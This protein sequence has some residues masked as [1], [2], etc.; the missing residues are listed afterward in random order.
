MTNDI[1][2]EGTKGFTGDLASELIDSGVMDELL[3]PQKSYQRKYRDTVRQ[4]LYN[5]VR[6][7][8]RSNAQGELAAVAIPLTK[9]REN[10]G[11]WGQG[12]LSYRRI[13]KILGVFE[14]RGLIS[15]TKGVPAHKRDM[16]YIRERLAG[17]EKPEGK[18]TTFF[19]T[20]DL[21]E[22]IQNLLEKR[23]DLASDVE[24]IVD[25]S[26]VWVKD[27]GTVKWVENRPE[28]ES[29]VR[30]VTASTPERGALALPKRD[31]DEPAGGVRSPIRGNTSPQPP[32][33]G[34]QSH[35]EALRRCPMLWSWKRQETDSHII[36]H[37][38]ETAFEYERKFCRGSFDCNGRYYANV[39]NIP[40]DWRRF[41]TL[42][43]EPVVEL[44]FDNL[45]FHML[46]AKRGLRLEGDAY[47]I[48]D[49]SL[50]REHI[51]LLANVMINARNSPQ[52]YAW[53]RKEEELDGYTKEEIKEAVYALRNRHAP[54]EDA[55]H[56]DAGIYLQNEDSEIAE[57]VMLETG[58]VG[59]H[60]GFMAPA[61]DE[62]RLRKAM[63]IAFAEAYD[64]YEIPVSREW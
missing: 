29:R 37:I 17:G 11:H 25:H 23:T 13:K 48:G 57:Q 63:K 4:V 40:S 38:P 58:A 62:D 12:F 8:S 60:D 53:S 20:G 14:S 47:D 52:L 7:Q 5:L 31:P 39:Q 22:E 45:H 46:Y 28:M 33:T 35:E 18:V 51:K 64:G 41:I 26:G 15:V 27:D 54:I 16:D 59:I 30:A 56:S 50:D 24:I 44:D 36:Y 19:A 10:V 61:T 49:V 6:A 32:E 1:L 42:E 3:P 9:L 21:Q 2:Y 43:G 34:I 55:F